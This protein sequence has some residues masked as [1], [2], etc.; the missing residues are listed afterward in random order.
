VRRSSI[1]PRADADLIAG[2]IDLSIG[3]VMSLAAY[4]TTALQPALGSCPPSSV[5]ASV[6]WRGRSTP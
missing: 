5:L 2:Q 6:L 3:S 4:A 1:R